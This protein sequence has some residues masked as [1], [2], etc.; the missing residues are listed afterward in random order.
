MKFL[1]PLALL[2]LGATAQKT[3]TK[4]DSGCDADYIVTNCLELEQSKVRH[5]AHDGF[6]DAFCSAIT[7]RRRTLSL[8]DVKL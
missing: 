6:V 8:Q 3:A 2:A 7:L 1:L 5:L 4:S